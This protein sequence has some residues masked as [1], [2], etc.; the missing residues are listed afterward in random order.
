MSDSQCIGTVYRVEVIKPQ[1]KVSSQGTNQYKRPSPPDGGG[2][3]VWGKPKSVGV[4]REEKKRSFLKKNALG[5]YPYCGGL[6][7][8]S[9]LR[10][11]TSVFISW[12]Y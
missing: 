5:G 7:P 4:P 8:R 6:S 3:V 10:H 1:S 11:A 2:E 9:I 12:L